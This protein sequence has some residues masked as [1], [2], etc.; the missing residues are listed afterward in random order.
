MNKSWDKRLKPC[1]FCGGAALMYE[2]NPRAKHGCCKVC[3]AEG[4]V[5]STYLAAARAWNK[6]TQATEKE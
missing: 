2:V 3:N 1:P 6:R 4:P 5:K